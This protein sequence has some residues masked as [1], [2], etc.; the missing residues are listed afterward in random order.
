LVTIYT[1]VL[2]IYVKLTEF[3]F[4]ATK[5]NQLSGYL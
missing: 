2:L 1:R 4:M 5:T 3:H